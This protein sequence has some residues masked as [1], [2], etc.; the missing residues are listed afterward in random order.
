MPKTVYDVSKKETKIIGSSGEAVTVTDGKLDVNAVI[1]PVTID[2]TG[3][4]TDTKQ[5]EQTTLLTTIEANQLP[6]GHNVTVDNQ[7]TE[8]PLPTSQVT[9]LTP[10]AAITGFATSAKQDTIIAQ[11]QTLNSLIPS[12]YDYIDLS[13]TGDNLTGVVFKTGGSGGTTVSTLTLAYSGSTLTS[14][15]KT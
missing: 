2:T 10:P 7:P 8:F 4:A 9:T 5:D 11:L 15:T 1:P 13:Y 14:V 12:V 3:L 6:D